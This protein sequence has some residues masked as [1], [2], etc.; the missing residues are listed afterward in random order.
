MSATSSH[1][2]RRQFLKGAG[3]AGAATALTACTGNAS[4]SEPEPKKAKNLIFLVADGMCNGTLAL[5]HHWSV[6]NRDRKLHWMQL[7]GRDGLTR[8]FME[9]CSASSPVTDSA[10]A[11]SAWGSGQRV[12]NGAINF[13]TK[14]EK[15]T[16]IYSYAQAAG[17]ATG[18]VTT[19]TVTHATPA[20][21]AASVKKRGDEKEIAKQYL[22]REIDV[23]LGGGVGHFQYPESDKNGVTRPAENLF[24][25]FEAKGYTVTRDLAGLKGAK[26]S[27]KLLGLF[28]GGHVP[29][30][31]DRKNDTSLSEVPSLPDMFEAALASLS[32]AK[33]GFVLQVEGGRVDHA[34]HANDAGTILHEQLEFDDC[35]PLALKFIE[36]NPDTLLIVTTDH[37]TGGCQLDGKGKSYVESGPALDG[38]NDIKQSFSWLEGRFK[39]EGK[40]DAALFEDA[41][42]IEPTAAQAKR[43]QD[44]IDDPKM[45][46]L[47]S[48]MTGVFADQLWQKTA[49][50][51]T[52]NNHTSEC[53]ELL[54][55]GPGSGAIP[56]FIEN[57]ELFGFMTQALDLAVEL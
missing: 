49:V 28:S 50:G 55:F 10:A 1:S 27:K 16:P 11:A 31:I 45:K 47:S 2:S 30:A 57:R 7:Y 44:A 37:G 9:T 17:K 5:A 8:S 51:W 23:I 35:I 52:S 32:G 25:D 22:E 24:S 26:G 40:F 36:K 43:I 13:S 6:H 34:G 56:H 21:F 18:L 54:A 15:L 4:I 3:L 53:V 42:G 19:C 12:N 20:G 48:F 14:G 46:Y 29:Y 39:Q 41:T 33:D 38:I